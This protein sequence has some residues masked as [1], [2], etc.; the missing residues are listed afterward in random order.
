MQGAG[1][2]HGELFTMV[3]EGLVMAGGLLP[4]SSALKDEAESTLCRGVLEDDRCWLPST[5][6]LT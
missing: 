3:T 1:G 2:S 5:L 4:T 6:L